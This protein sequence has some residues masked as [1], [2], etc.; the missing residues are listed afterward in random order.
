MLVWSY[1]AVWSTDPFE[2]LVMGA[3]ARG[4]PA[5]WSDLERQYP[6][7][8]A[9]HS[10]F[11]TFNALLAGLPEPLAGA[12]AAATELPIG[13]RTLSPRGVAWLERQETI[14]AQV[15]ERLSERRNWDFGFLRE[16]AGRDYPPL[17]NYHMA[18][19]ALLRTQAQWEFERGR[20][21]AGV[22]GL[23][24]AVRLIRYNG[25]E[26]KLMGLLVRHSE[27]ESMHEPLRHLLG[28]GRGRCTELQLR[29]LQEAFTRLLEAPTVSQILRIEWAVHLEG[30]RSTSF[31]IPDGPAATTLKDRF[32]NF[33]LG[34]A[35]ALSASKT[36]DTS[37]YLRIAAARCDAFE[38]TLAQR[39]QRSQALVAEVAVI[40]KKWNRPLFRM[41]DA[42][43]PALNQWEFGATAWV[44]AAVTTLAVERFRLKYG[45]L[46]VDT[47]VLVPEFLPEVLRDPI[48]DLPLRYR[49]EA[50][51]F[52]VYSI[53][54]NARDDAGQLNTVNDP[55][56]GAKAGG[57]QGIRVP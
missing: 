46:P 56:N 36:A 42:N 26:Y 15:Q 20:W 29:D 41:M 55:V 38:G 1:R 16:D 18:A 34:C 7:Q 13:G 30:L 11:L 14:V 39:Q 21:D 48:D 57:D 6:F 45:Q 3:R 4:L 22:A 28:P 8:P 2:S 25:G 23:I 31:W 32:T 27:T 49:R 37:D 54:S 43:F 12:D 50:E 53:G 40:R 10:N 44:R 51:G 9:V 47:A 52:V 19:A 35:Y 33:L 5:S 17:E 24:S